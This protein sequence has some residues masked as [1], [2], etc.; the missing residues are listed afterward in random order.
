MVAITIAYYYK[1]C[2]DCLTK[3]IDWK[4]FLIGYFF[5]GLLMP[6][7]RTV[8]P[9]FPIAWHRDFEVPLYC[10]YIGLYIVSVWLEKL[11]LEKNYLYAAIVMFMTGLVLFVFFSCKDTIDSNTFSGCFDNADSLPVVLMAS[12]IFYVTKYLCFVVAIPTRCKKIISEISKCTLGIYLIHM[13]F[14]NVLT[15]IPWYKEHFALAGRSYRLTV[16][17]QILTF[18]I[19]GTISAVVRRIP[20]VRRLF[21]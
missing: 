21:T 7:L 10:G 2:I 19:C 9:D 6:F 20:V 11:P 12:G 17:L 5:F 18:V 15:F 3:K 8:I 16:I 14:L 4:V 1:R 13:M